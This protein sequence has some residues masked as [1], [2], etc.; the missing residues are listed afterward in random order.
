MLQAIIFDFDGVIVDS[1]PLHFQATQNVLSSLGIH[2]DYP[3]YV[4]E[5]AGQP[6]FNNFQRICVKHQLNPVELYTQK[7]LDEKINQ[8]R[9]LLKTAQPCVGAL[10]LIKNAA[11][12]Y[13]LGICSGSFKNEI[14]Q[15]LSILDK[16]DLS[17]Y[18]KH[19]VTIEDVPSGKPDPAGYRMIAQKLEVLP[20]YCLAIEDSPAGIIAAK[21]AGMS[22]L[23]VTHTHPKEK[24]TLADY[25]VSNL[26]DIQVNDLVNIG[27]AKI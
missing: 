17:R 25:C 1:E 8:Y 23:A 22:V 2:I 10:S 21:T 26:A 20:E 19:I 16:E 6:D 15:L 27:C 13:P 4:Q 7:L 5:C 24:L 11:A 3:S 12:H 14:N 9:T 18:F